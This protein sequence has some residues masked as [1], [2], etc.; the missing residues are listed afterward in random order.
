M[1]GSPLLSVIA[2]IGMTS[3]STSCVL[4]TLK[5]CPELIR[6]ASRNMSSQTRGIP[7]HHQ[8]HDAGYRL[9]ELP[10]EVQS[11]L[12]SDT[13]PVSVH[14]RRAHR[15][16]FLSAN[17]GISLQPHPRGVRH[18]C[19][20]P[21]ARQLVP[22]APEKHLQCPPPA[23]PAALALIPRTGPL[24]HMHHP[25]DGRAR[26]HPRP[27][28]KPSS[29]QGHGEPRQV[30]RK[31]RQGPVTLAPSPR[32]GFQGFYGRHHDDFT[33]HTAIHHEYIR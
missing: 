29:A 9:I 7:L 6:T 16:V 28:H 25:R 21:H 26:G 5:H 12:E 1:R 2:L 32:Q 23:G 11:M 17:A 8:P 18:I 19:H 30:A 27:A 15:G 20:P 33:I 10:M 4:Q 14:P 3:T 31:V 24:H 22:P 13:A